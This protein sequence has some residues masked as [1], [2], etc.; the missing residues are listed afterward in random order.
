MQIQ[1]QR[2]KDVT[3]YN[4]GQHECEFESDTQNL[5]YA[6][7]LRHK[8]ENNIKMYLYDNGGHGLTIGIVSGFTVHFCTVIGILFVILL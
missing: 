2:S 4:H 6:L 5:S 1:K 7:T 3:L 8:W